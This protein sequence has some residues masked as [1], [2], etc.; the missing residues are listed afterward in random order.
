MLAKEL[1]EFDLWE[2]YKNKE[3]K[4]N[5]CLHECKKSRMIE[6]RDILKIPANRRK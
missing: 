5:E 6:D 3:A 2:T 1:I 4:N